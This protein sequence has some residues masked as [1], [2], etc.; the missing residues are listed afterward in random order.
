MDFN[1][2]GDCFASIHAITLTI[3]EAAYWN[4]DAMCQIL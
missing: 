3:I 1:F 2:H 4:Q